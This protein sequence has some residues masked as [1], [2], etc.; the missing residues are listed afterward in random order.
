MENRCSA[1]VS[2]EAQITHILREMG[3]P[4]HIVGYQYVREAI[5]ITVCDR[6]M[7]NA[8]TKE[9]YPALAKTFSTKPSNVD[10]AMRYAIEV[11]WGRGD[12]EILRSFFGYRLGSK[13][14]RP[15][16]SEFIATISD[17]LAPQSIA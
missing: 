6:K 11:A 7:I 17:Y 15:N 4:A 5:V 13:A 14:G 16:N 9:L 8:V 3:I 1:H 12:T 10:R 2:L